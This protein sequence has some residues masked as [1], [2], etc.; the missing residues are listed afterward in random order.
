M[1]ACTFANACGR[2]CRAVGHL[3]C[4]TG[5][6][7]HAAEGAAF[8]GNLLCMADLAFDTLPGL[9]GQIAF[10][11]APRLA[12]L[13]LLN[14]PPLPHQPLPSRPP[15]A[16]VPGLRR[17]PWSGS[18]EGTTWQQRRSAVAH[19]RQQ[20][21]SHTCSMQENDESRFSFAQLVFILSEHSSP[22]VQTERSLSTTPLAAALLPGPRTPPWRLLLLPR[23]P[24]N[25][26]SPYLA[27]RPLSQCT[28]HNPNTT[29][30]PF[31]SAWA[32]WPGSWPPDAWRWRRRTSALRWLACWRTWSRPGGWARAAGCGCTP[33]TACWS[34]RWT[35]THRWEHQRNTR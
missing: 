27:L 11:G 31:R 10:H 14:V 12:A 7:G 23:Q 15:T 25:S 22:R 6:D 21:K 9:P 19:H 34:R 5:P 29:H 30:R 32:C 2:A 17:S 18:S 20:A 24:T 3:D 28:T 16:F 1:T 4:F 13:L 8:Q 33:W 35:R 26:F